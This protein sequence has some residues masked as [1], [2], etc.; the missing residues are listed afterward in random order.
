M[1]ISMDRR[2][3]LR[4]P[5]RLPI[6]V[7]WTT[8]SGIAE[9]HTESQDVSSRG[10]YFHVPKQIEDGSQ[11]D[12]VLSL[13]NEI[14]LVG[15]MQVSCTGHVKRTELIELDRIGVAAQIEHYQFLRESKDTGELVPAKI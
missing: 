1:R 15:R 12:I 3:T 7:R 14:T 4:F 9:I 8:P 6:T 13:P 11:V 5:L 10:V 2:V